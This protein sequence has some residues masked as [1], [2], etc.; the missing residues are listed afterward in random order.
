MDEGRYLESERV[1]RGFEKGR[2]RLYMEEEVV[3]H[4]K[5]G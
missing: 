5:T 4:T 1:T 3:K 2:R